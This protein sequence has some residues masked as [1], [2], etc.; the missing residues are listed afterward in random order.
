MLV[1]AIGSTGGCSF[2]FVHGPS[3]YQPPTQEPDCTRAPP[4]P[5]IDALAAT[6][7]V[8]A[9]V[10]GLAGGG[11]EGG[12]SVDIGPNVGIPL[13]AIGVAETVSA[14]YGF[15]KVKRCYDAYG[16]YQARAQIVDFV[17]RKSR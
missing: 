8:A 3:P 10:S 6:F 12:Q 2:V 14:I 5:I 7:F 17:Q 13:L 11:Y 9:G 15:V 1:I 4:I 16:A